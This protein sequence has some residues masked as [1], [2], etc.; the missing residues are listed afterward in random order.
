MICTPHQI[1]GLS[2]G[3]VAHMGDRR[4]AYRNLVRRPD[5]KRPNGRPRHRWEENTTMDLQELEWGGTDWIDLC[6]DYLLKFYQ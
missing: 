4:S 5:G 2:N 6:N 3:N 1:F